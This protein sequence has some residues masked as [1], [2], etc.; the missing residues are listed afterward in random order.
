MK[1]CPH[2]GKQLQ[3]IEPAEAH[4]YRYGKEVWAKT[5]CCGKVVRCVPYINFHVYS[6]SETVD[7]WGN[8]RDEESSCN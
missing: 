1:P 5:E 8:Q 6:S 7:S 2:C 4:M 3:L